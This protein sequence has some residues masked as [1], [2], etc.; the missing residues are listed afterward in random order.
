MKKSEKVGAIKRIQEGKAGPS[1][2]R[3]ALYK[4]EI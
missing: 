1:S 4:L 2:N 3:A